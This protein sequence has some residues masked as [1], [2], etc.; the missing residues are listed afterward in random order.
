MQK[1]LVWDESKKSLMCDTFE[2]S[3]TIKRERTVQFQRFVKPAS[4][5]SFKMGGTRKLPDKNWT[6]FNLTPN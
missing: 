2:L 4:F 5:F 6:D 1:L 3:D